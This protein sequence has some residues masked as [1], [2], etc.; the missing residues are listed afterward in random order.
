MKK[1]DILKLS[2]KELL[3][4]FNKFK[5]NNDCNNCTYCDECNN[6]DD[7]NSCDDCD[8]CCFCYDLNNKKYYILNVKFSKKEY[9]EF[10]KKLK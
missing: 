8:D 10:I 1:E 3:I 2:K 5:K 7:C 4:N 9:F 6:C